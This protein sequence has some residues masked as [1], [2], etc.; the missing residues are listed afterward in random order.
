MVVWA[1][2]LE[3]VVRVAQFERRLIPCHFLGGRVEHVDIAFALSVSL[4]THDEDF[5]GVDGHHER[6]KP[7]WQDIW[8][9][10]D[11]VPLSCASVR[12]SLSVEL[13]NAVEITIVS[14]VAAE[15][16]EEST[17]GTAA[18]TPSGLVEVRTCEPLV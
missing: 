7:T 4:A 6:V 18:V 2:K 11:Q 1:V 10:R 16:E 3:F 14:V 17:L 5:S 8:A 12:V 9:D 13:L 15:D